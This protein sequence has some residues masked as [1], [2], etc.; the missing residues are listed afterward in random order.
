MAGVLL[1]G[2]TV[3]FSLCC[4]VLFLFS[5]RAAGAMTGGRP[6]ALPVPLD[7]TLRTTANTLSVWY[8][9]SGQISFVWPTKCQ[10][11]AAG[12]PFQEKL[13]LKSK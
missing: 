10:Q 11:L 4:S 13:K 9:V 1:R 6:V 8:G 12:S 5:A 3:T 7:P 2:V